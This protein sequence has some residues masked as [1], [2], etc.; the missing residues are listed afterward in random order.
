VSN[1]LPPSL[2]LVISASQF[3]AMLPQNILED[4]LSLFIVAEINAWKKARGE[5]SVTGGK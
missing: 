2:F 1:I 3:D 4:V 5:S